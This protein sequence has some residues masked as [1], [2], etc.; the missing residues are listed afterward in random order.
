M[1]IKPNHTCI[2]CGS[3]Y[4]FCPNC[5]EYDYLPRWMG[6]FCSDNCHDI[7]EVANDYTHKLMTKEEATEAVKNL[8]FSKRANYT[9]G[10]K[11]AINEIL[12]EKDEEKSQVE[13]NG[14]EKIEKRESQEKNVISKNVSD[15]K[16]TSDKDMKTDN[17]VKTSNNNGN[18]ST[19]DTVKNVNDTVMNMSFKKNEKNKF[20][21]K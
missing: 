3:K 19:T 18:K 12:G 5:T 20:Y 16:S 11:K 15:S 8:D 6:N 21:K 2:V 17:T 4:T 9:G 14:T 1:R 13:E 7:F 10:V